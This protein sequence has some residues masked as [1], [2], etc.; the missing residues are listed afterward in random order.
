[1]LS[2]RPTVAVPPVESHDVQRGDISFPNSREEAERMGVNRYH[3]K[4]CKHCDSTLKRVKKGDCYA[5]HRSDS[6]MRL[7]AQLK[8]PEGAVRKKLQNAE[9]KARERTQTPPW[10]DK[11]AIAAI[12]RQAR[13]EGLEVDHVIPLAGQFVSGLHVAAN[14]QLISP[15]ANRAKGNSFNPSLFAYSASSALGASALRCPSPVLAS[16][17]LRL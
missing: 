9:Y 6:I 10:A 3:R 1:M 4:P 2:I 5:C 12:R 11:K 13:A 14:L 17:V 7:K 8:T 16:H 15:A